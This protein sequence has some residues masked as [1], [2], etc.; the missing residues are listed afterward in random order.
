[1]DLNPA[2]V[3][4]SLGWGT[5]GVHQVGEI[6]LVNGAYHAVVWH[7]TGASMV[8]LSPSDFTGIAAAYGVSGN[9]Q[10]GFAAANGSGDHAML[11]DGSP[12]SAVDLHPAGFF[13]SQA[14]GSNGTI[15]VGDGYL[16]SLS[17]PSYALAWS[18]SAASA[19][20]L[21]ALLPAG[22]NNSIAYTVDSA[23]DVFGLAEDSAGI[24]HAIEWVP[25]P[26]SLPVLLIGVI[27]VRRR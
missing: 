10:V 15:Q 11:W 2:G 4:A 24:E 26:L 8:D 25:E 17:S 16:A 22:F 5:D 14:F 12:D 3:T 27:L 9:Q 21:A 23:G 7:G 19:I 20:D 18:G 13:S 1:V 6:S